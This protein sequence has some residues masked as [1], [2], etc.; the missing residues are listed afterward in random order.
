MKTQNPLQ[1]INNEA[2]L[3]F[4]L[5]VGCEASRQTVLEAELLVCRELQFALHAPD[6]L[7]FVETL[8][9]V[10]GEKPDASLSSA[11]DGD[12]Q[13]LLRLSVRRTQRAVRPLGGAAPAEPA[14]SPVRHPAE[15]QHL[16]GAAGRD[17]LLCQALRPT[18]VSGRLAA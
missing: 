13:Q 6:P 16:P 4:L 8:L 12:K 14:C 11:T 3:H 18:Q 5:S 9:E 15:E 1:R 17:H 10:L 7:T 2:A